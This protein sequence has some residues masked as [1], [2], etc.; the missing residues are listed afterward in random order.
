MDWVYGVDSSKH[1]AAKL[2]TGFRSTFRITWDY[3]SFMRFT[4]NFLNFCRFLLLLC[5]FFMPCP[6]DK[7]FVFVLLSVIPFRLLQCLHSKQLCMLL[8]SVIQE[9]RLLYTFVWLKCRN[10]L[11]WLLCHA[12]ITIV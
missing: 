9:V 6:H 11:P 1:R 3:G 4:Q 10:F 12:S 7:F 5:L 8:Y 2:H